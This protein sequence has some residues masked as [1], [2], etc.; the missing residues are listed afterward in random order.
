M[1]NAEPEEATANPA[2]FTEAVKDAAPGHPPSRDR[3]RAMNTRGHDSYF[4][5]CRRAR[6]WDSYIGWSATRTSR[7]TRGTVEVVFSLGL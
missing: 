3:I 6:I 2:P 7:A 1:E 5:G 4:R